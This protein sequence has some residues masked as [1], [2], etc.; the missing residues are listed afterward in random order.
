VSIYTTPTGGTALEQFIKP[1]S[2]FNGT[3]LYVE[4]IA[5]GS[6]TLSWSYSEQSDC[7]D[8]IK[9]TVFKV[10]TECLAAAPLPQTRTRIGVCE[11]VS[12]TLQP[13]SL[14]PVTWSIS[15]DGLLSATTGNPIT[16][17]AH[18][19]A[20]AP[21]ITAT[22]GGAACE[23]SFTIVEPDG[24]Y[25]VQ[26]GNTIHWQGTASAGF[27]GITY[28]TPKDVS[29]ENLEINEGT[30]VGVG[31]GCLLNLNGQVHSPWPSWASV[32]TGNPATGCVVE[33]PNQTGGTYWDCIYTF[34]GGGPWT[35]GTFTW[36]IPWEFRKPGGSKKQ[37]TTLTHYAEVEN[38]TGKTTQSKGGVTVLAMPSDPTENP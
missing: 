32:S 8:A 24:A 9:A 5:P 38:V 12:L 17:T 31:T 21:T 3:N 36:P 27:R 23:V 29:F 34:A 11:Q 20:S 28:L 4:G 10:D 13:S 14:S 15:G 16:F 18:D 19:R 1:F 33:G 35:S 6:N 25:Q 30:C 2:G 22:Y 26:F 7:V 37:F